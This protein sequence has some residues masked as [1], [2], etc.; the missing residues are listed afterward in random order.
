MRSIS[1]RGYRFP[2]DIIQH[3]VWLYLRFA[4]SFRDVEDLLAERGIVVSYET[5]RRWVAHFGPLIAADLRRRRC[6]PHAIWHLD[7]MVVSIAGKPKYLWRAVD[8][9]GEVLEVLIQRKRD[10]RAAA[11]LMRKL[12]KKQ[13]FAPTEIVTD[14][15]RSY[16][17]A[18][19]ALG[20]SAQHIQGKRKNNR[21]ESSHLPDPATRAADAGLSIARRRPALP[22]RSRRCLQHFQPLPT[23]GQRQD[24]PTPPQRG[25]RGVAKRRGRHGVIDRSRTTPLP[26]PNNVT[27]PH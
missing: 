22:V 24:P 6:R 20:V 3:G 5:I 1:Y 2:P 7:E 25:H 21:A 18:F 15:L 12:L 8:A 27:K 26:S 16:G 13:G 14:H 23:S 17:A 10:T 11:R 4:L 9:E 19:R